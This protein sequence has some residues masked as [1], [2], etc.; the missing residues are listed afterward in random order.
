MY[1]LDLKSINYIQILFVIFIITMFLGPAI[2]DI[3]ASL[4][5]VYCLY[6]LMKDKKI[7]ENVLILSFFFI[8]LLIPN[9]F[10][11]YLPYALVEFIVN[12]RYFL[13]AYF[14]AIYSN[15]KIEFIIKILFIFTFILSIDLILQY[16]IG[17]NIIGIPIESNHGG[18]RASSF[19]GHELVAGSYILKFGLPVLGYLLY[20][21]KYL[22]FFLLLIIFEIAIICTGERMTFLLFG[23]GIMTILILKKINFLKLIAIGIICVLTLF[24]LY[25]VEERV[26][27]RTQDFIN[28]FNTQDKNYFYGG[29]RAHFLTAFEIF[30]NYPYFGTG[31]RT[32]R[33][34]CDKDEI[35]SKIKTNVPGCSTHPH[36][37]YLEILSDFG[38]F[39]L[40]V[41]LIS[42]IILLYKF[43]KNDTHKNYAMGFF[44]SFIT[45]IWPISSSGNF[46]NN[47]V[48][49]MN[50]FILGILLL[51]SK[52]N[53]FYQNLNKSNTNNYIDN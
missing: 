44:A 53:C 47:R 24:S 21:N 38:L 20:K 13:F 8:F 19:F 7:D 11:N 17:Y 6:L 28:S 27:I 40:I 32:F 4:L 41:F 31:H 48:A 14:I 9:L 15:L 1:N 22:V 18:T 23:L 26:K 5:S 33:I 2:P 39:G 46:F 16:I 34:A 36:N 50:F 49:L 25:S 52:K 51:Y 3:I 37:T 35:K 10:S 45:I 30:K 29:H 42:T 43:I 12:I